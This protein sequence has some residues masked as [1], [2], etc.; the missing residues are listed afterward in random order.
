MSQCCKAVECSQRDGGM[1][2]NVISCILLIISDR[3]GDILILTAS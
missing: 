2:C 3:D 1:Y